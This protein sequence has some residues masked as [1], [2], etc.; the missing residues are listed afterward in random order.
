MERHTMTQAMRRRL[1]VAGFI[2][3]LLLLGGT[4]LYRLIEGWSWID[5]LY[6]TTATITTVGYGDFVPTH[7]ISKLATI[8]YCFVGIGTFLYL[9]STI[10]VE[11]IRY[12]ES[13]L[14]HR[15]EEEKT[16]KSENISGK[17]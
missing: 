1:W 12:Q 8:F 14:L 13:K 5:S 6:F 2:L 11:F 10:G 17:D 3:F 9:V 7:N 16:K 15:F 4:L